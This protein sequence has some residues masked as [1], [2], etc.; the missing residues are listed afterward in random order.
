MPISPAD[1]EREAEEIR[2]IYAEAERTIIEKIARRVARGIDTADDSWYAIKLTEVSQLRRE[3]EAEIRRLRQADREIERVVATA[4]REGSTA[5]IADLR[6]VTRAS[7]AIRTAF[8]RANED[9]VRRLAQ[10]VVGNL[11]ATQFRILRAAEDVYRQVIAETAVPQVLTG[12]L[13][14]R[15][16]A[17]RALD[18]FAELGISG[19][20]DRAGRSWSLES[21]AEMA[22][23]TGLGQAAVQGHIDKL[24]ENNRDLVIVSDSPDECEKCRPWEGRILSL[25]G[26]TP[27]YPTADQ[28]RAAGLFHPNCT[29][30]FGLYV[31]GLTRPMSGTAAP[32]RYEE[33]QQQRYIERQ[34]RKWKL[35]EAAAITDD[36]KRLASAKVRDWQAVMRR[37]IAET[38]RIRKPSRE[39]I[40]KAR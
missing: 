31:P 22:V 40:G 38:G 14:R 4:Y 32:Q 17:Q 28:A 6:R 13:T 30:R 34:I 16:A 37:F 36:A 23:R 33:R 29:H 5:A 19:F 8:T 11:E 20:V 7:V 24:I 15:E 39:Q 18:R 35:R 2:R 12:V 27:G 3:V 26:Q 1:A 21:Y 25:T 10:A 9:A